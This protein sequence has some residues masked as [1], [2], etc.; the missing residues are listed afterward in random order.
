MAE[1]L[2]MLPRIT[3]YH[4]QDGCPVIDVDTSASGE[5]AHD[6]GGEPWLR[7]A[8]N[9]HDIHDQSPSRPL[10]GSRQAL[11]IEEPWDGPH[12]ELHTL[13]PADPPGKMT[14]LYK[15]ASDGEAEMLDDLRRR[16]GI[17]WEHVGCSTN[18]YGSNSCERCGELRVELE[19]RGEVLP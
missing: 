1:P 11:S 16:A 17:T 12:D 15:F 9:D 2:P 5:V 18:L 3:V 6:E 4:G 13:D 19:E 14:R 10:P 7:I 8:I